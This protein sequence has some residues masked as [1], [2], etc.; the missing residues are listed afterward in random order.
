MRKIFQYK[1]E[2]TNYKTA[3]TLSEILI[4]I[5]IIGIVAA[6]LIPAIIQK[7]TYKMTETRLARFYSLI[8][9]AIS[10]SIID[11]GAP[12]TWDYWISDE[13]DDEDNLLNQNEATDVAF[14]KYLA[15]YLKIVDKREVIDGDGDKRILYYLADGSAFAYVRHQIR[16]WE[17]F[18]HKAE[19]CI[20]LKKV[21]TA[22]ICRFCFEFYP[23]NV[24]N[25][26]SDELWKY[27]LNKGLE[28][29]LHRWDGNLETLFNS[30]RYG[31][32][33][34]LS[35]SYCTAII[36]LN[37]WKIPDNYPRKIKY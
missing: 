24:S 18:P 8:N 35:G 16:D 34:G 5:L 36:A 25:M 11:N 20:V 3:F 4:S 31:C 17:F 26:G 2:F 14:Q 33:P 10:M 19:K 7:Y 12:E 32:N 23:V 27:L 37:S 22:G 9:Q 1:S 15:P 6:L 28:P 30:E 13:Y 21:D 29:S